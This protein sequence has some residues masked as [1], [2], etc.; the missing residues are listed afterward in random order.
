[1]S[2]LE[3]ARRLENSAAL[4]GMIGESIVNGDLQPGQKLNEAALAERFHVS[5]GPIREALRRLAERRLVVFASNA[6]A[7]V[8]TYTLQD[9]LHL[10][11]V[12]EALEGLAARLAAEHMTEVQ[13][14]DLRALFEAHTASIEANPTG[15]YLQVPQDLDFHYR[16]ALGAQNPILSQLLCEDLYLVLR[17]CRTQHRKVTNRGHRAWEEHRRVLTAIEEGDAEMADFVMRRHIAAAR[18]SIQ[19]GLPFN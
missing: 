7:R 2:L 1:M 11:R 19:S 3:G 15:L 5:R 8:A 10:L 14:S 16:I 4:A 17:L 6:G 12:R 18:E 13:K 9:M